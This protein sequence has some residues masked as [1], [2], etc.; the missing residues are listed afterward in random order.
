[1]VCGL[2][3]RA[4]HDVVLAMLAKSVVFLTPENIETVLLEESFNHSAW[5]L[6]NLYLAGLGAK[7]LSQDA[8]DIVGL[9]QD[10]TCYISPL[11]FHEEDRFADF[12]V[13]EAAH[14]FHNCKRNTLGLH[15]TRSRFGCW[16]SSTASA[17]PLRTRVKLTR[18]S[19]NWEPF[20]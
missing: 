13:H 9:S 10:T 1:M 15:E 7:L 17:R 5:T 4:E 12:I 2:F 11:Y 3:P 14:V 6:A 18:A 16:I 8:P 20:R 19:P